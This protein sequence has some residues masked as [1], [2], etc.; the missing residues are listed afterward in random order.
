MGINYYS[1]LD[2]SF[3]LDAS[4][5]IKIATNK[6]A[7]EQSLRNIIDTIIG[8]RGGVGQETFGCNLKKYLFHQISP[9]VA[10]ALGE[11]ILKTLQ[12]F[13][14]RVKIDHVQ[15]NKGTDNKSYEIQVDYIVTNIQETKTFS[16]KFAL[17]VL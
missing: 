7:V 17:S 15:V 16:Y 2:S 4:G 8:F 9:Q 13:E 11:E 1:D 5:D 6:T 3:G 12:N 14:P 10:E